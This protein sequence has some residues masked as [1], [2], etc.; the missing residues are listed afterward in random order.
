M[1]GWPGIGDWLDDVFCWIGF[2]SFCR[3]NRR[4][5]VPQDFS[6][7]DT[8]ERIGIY[9][10]PILETANNIDW[11]K[12]RCL[13]DAGVNLAAGLGTSANPIL[14][15]IALALDLS[16]TD[17][18]IFQG[19]IQAWGD[20]DLLA[21]HTGISGDISKSAQKVQQRRIDELA[22]VRGKK[23]GRLDMLKNLKTLKRASR[24]L[25]V[26]AQILE[27]ADFGLTAYKCV[28]GD[29]EE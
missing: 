1:P 16:G 6:G 26:A 23:P 10:Q 15:G 25:P 14:A 19:E 13:L 8:V 18:N 20:T 3:E 5:E 12:V 22:G 4:E 11:K 24:I 27:V 28:W 7:Q 2:S 9:L 21:G 17:I 29:N